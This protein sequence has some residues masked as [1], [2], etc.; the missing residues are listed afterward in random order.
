MKS[1]NVEKT[2]VYCRAIVCL[3]G[4]QGQYFLRGP[5]RPRAPDP[6]PLIN[7]LLLSLHY[8]YYIILYVIIY[9]MEYIQYYELII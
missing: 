7:L 2:I 5:P 4:A 9:Y 8:P 6:I 1:S 3:S